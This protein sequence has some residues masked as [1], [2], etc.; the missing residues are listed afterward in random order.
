[1]SV[2]IQRMYGEWRGVNAV[3]CGVYGVAGRRT[4]AN[5]TKATAR[6]S[7]KVCCITGVI[8]L[9]AVYPRQ[10][11]LNKA[12]VYN[13]HPN[14]TAENGSGHSH[15]NVCWSDRRYSRVKV[16]GR[17]EEENNVRQAY[18]RIATNGR[19]PSSVVVARHHCMPETYAAVVGRQSH[20]P[21]LVINVVARP[22]LPVTAVLKAS[23]TRRRY[24]W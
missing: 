2:H 12:L 4:S 15:A 21:V 9:P 23:T 5:P 18:S 17:G 3:V 13:S 7:P 1:M 16:N 6:V 20:G 24:P 14:S 22:S 10:V 11:F 19:R 8:A